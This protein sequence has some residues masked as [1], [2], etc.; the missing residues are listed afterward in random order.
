MQAIRHVDMHTPGLL[1]LR[2]EVRTD[3]GVIEYT[4]LFQTTCDAVMDA[5]ERFPQSG[6]VKV[7][8]WRKS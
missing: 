8:M 6:A 2:V 1:K 3:G 5:W 4:G 7:S